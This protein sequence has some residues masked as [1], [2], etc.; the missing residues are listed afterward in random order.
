MYKVWRQARVRFIGMAGVFCVA[1]FLLMALLSMEGIRQRLDGL[2]PYLSLFLNNCALVLAFSGALVDAFYTRVQRP[3]LVTAMSALYA[4]IILGGMTWLYKTELVFLAPQRDW[5]S[6]QNPWPTTPATLMFTALVLGYAVGAGSVLAIHY[7]RLLDSETNYLVRVRHG[8]TFLSVASLTAMFAMLVV[9]SFFT[10]AALI[11][12]PIL[13]ALVQLFGLISLAAFSLHVLPAFASRAV[14]RGL[15]AGIQWW[16]LWRLQPLLDRIEA[17]PATAELSRPR[18][19]YG[20]PPFEQLCKAAIYLLDTRAL[21]ARSPDTQARQLVARLDEALGAGGAEVG[22]V[23]E[24]VR[25]SIRISGALNR[26]DGR[27]KKVE[28]IRRATG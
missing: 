26:R 10:G 24:I 27:I 21:L 11:S 22:R 8:A 4:S 9:K 19:T 16:E 25:N 13:L 23:P 2:S 7:W 15:V 18:P 28:A 20:A 14:T 1:M 12:P 3:A 5:S 17:Q 6:F